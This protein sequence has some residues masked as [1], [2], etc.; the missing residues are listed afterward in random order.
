M[1]IEGFDEEHLEQV[2]WTN[3]TP[4]R[5]ISDPPHMRP[6]EA[7]EADRMGF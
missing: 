7:A 3:L 4:A 2:L 1:E 5:A 6:R